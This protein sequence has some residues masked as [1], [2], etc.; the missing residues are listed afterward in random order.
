MA[1]LLSSH[2]W[3]INFD[4]YAFSGE[5]FTQGEHYKEEQF[6][7]ALGYHQRWTSKRSSWYIFTEK[8]VSDR[9]YGDFLGGR[10]LS[11]FSHYGELCDWKGVRT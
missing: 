3:H 6:H 1:I 8:K 11:P 9:W 10:H 7:C 4:F 2:S 5:E